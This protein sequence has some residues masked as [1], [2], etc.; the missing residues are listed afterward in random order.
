M[1]YLIS[2]ANYERC[3]A[4]MTDAERAEFDRDF[5]CYPNRVSPD[6]RIDLDQVADA[7]LEMLARDGR[8]RPP[9]I[10]GP[11]LVIYPKGSG[12]QTLLTEFDREMF[13]PDPGPAPTIAEQAEAP[14]RPASA[15]FCGMYEDYADVGESPGHWE[16]RD[17]S[18]RRYFLNQWVDP[19]PQP[20]PVGDLLAAQRKLREMDL[21][22]PKRVACG[23]IALAVFQFIGRPARLP[24]Y[25][26]RV[27]DLTGV[28]IVAGPDLPDD[29]WQLLDADTGEVLHEA[30]IN[31]PLAAFMRDYLD[32]APVGE[33]A[34][35]ADVP[36]DVLF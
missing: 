7:Y 29:V 31:P 25:D 22:R 33:L 24:A 18:A 2:R 9:R 16:D 10:L 5:M 17:S 14:S 23:E 26:G 21:P 36:R 32:Q 19:D 3:T 20:D 34:D 27:G 30:R 12:K 15:A 13:T 35:Q 1:T 4:G 28:P 6:A 11:Q 8:P